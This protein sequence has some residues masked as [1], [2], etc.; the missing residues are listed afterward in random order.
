MAG[1][2][3][4]W[5]PEV[6]DLQRR[7]ARALELGGEERVRRQHEQG[8][9]TIRERLDRLVDPGSFV[10]YGAIAGGTV[11]EDD[12]SQRFVPAGFVA[13]LGKING[14][15]TAVGGEDFT[16][17][18]GSEGGAGGRKGRLLQELARD[19]RVPLVWLLDGAGA[20]VRSIGQMG[21][22]SLPK[23][24]GWAESASLSG[25]I[26]LVSCVVGS[27]AGGPALTAVIGDIVIMVK[28]TSHIFAGGPPLVERSLGHKVT[29]EELGG[30][31]LHTAVSGVADLEVASEDACLATAREYL[32]YFP[33]NCW[34]L[35]AR[36]DNGDP[37][38]RR[39]E[40]LLSAVPRSYR[41]LYDMRPIL[42]AVVDSGKLFEIKPA[43]GPSMITTLARLNG[44][45][46][47]IIASQPRVIGGAIDGPAAD[48]GAH[49]VQLCDAFHIPL[50]FFVDCPGF[51]IGIK[52]ESEGTLRRGLRV[53]HAV[54]NSRVPTIS[55]VIRK[56]YG[57]GGAAYGGGL[58][59]HLNLV[60]PSAQFGS[61]PIEGGVA[62]AYR[63]VIESSPD[64]DKTRRDLEA[65]L[66]SMRTP[67]RAAEAMDV[68]DVIDPRDTRPLLIKYLD[69]AREKTRYQLGPRVSYGIMP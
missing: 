3:P 22:S 44:Y 26:P 39:E 48:K 34:E 30:S 27:I 58:G 57:M 32:S 52:A 36:V 54:A 65:Q 16:V 63:R 35:P 7:R 11:R 42:K 18:G 24:R 41:Q 66:D 4:T 8:K 31:R 56:S 12:G 29:K 10:E 28:E 45:P 59:A 47:G 40:A 23:G 1:Q 20:S 21:Y 9:L 50:V 55:V 67:W 68:E 62:A 38:D 33:Q 25:Q 49:F 60:W 69:V 46:V 51:M 14:R 61:I 6:E 2:Q 15:W 19:Y 43:Y 53:T 13:G 17:R 5:L 37:P 64:P